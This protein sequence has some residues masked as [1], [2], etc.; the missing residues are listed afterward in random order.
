MHWLSIG[1][2]SYFIVF[3]NNNACRHV[4]RRKNRC[5]CQFGKLVLVTFH[6]YLAVSLWQIICLMNAMT[7]GLSQMSFPENSSHKNLL[8]MLEHHLFSPPLWSLPVLILRHPYQVC[9]WLSHKINPRTRSDISQQSAVLYSHPWKVRRVL[10]FRWKRWSSN[11]NQKSSTKISMVNGL[12]PT[13][14]EPWPRTSYAMTWICSARHIFEDPTFHSW[15][16]SMN[17]D[18]RKTLRHTASVKL[19]AISLRMSFIE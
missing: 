7:P 1:R 19:T 15:K 8:Q 4:K 18:N 5:R 16:E 13:S 9:F 12:S 11:C 2:R 17:K 14:L 6:E 3:S 10:L